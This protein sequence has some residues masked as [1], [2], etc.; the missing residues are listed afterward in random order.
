MIFSS[1]AMEP[2]EEPEQWSCSECRSW[3]T[4]DGC[5]GICAVA[6]GRFYDDGIEN[7]PKYMALNMTIDWVL[8]NLR[9]CEHDAC[10]EFEEGGR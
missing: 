5:T 4:Q 7:T 10:G 8:G 1:L 6:L 3:W 9:D 2:P